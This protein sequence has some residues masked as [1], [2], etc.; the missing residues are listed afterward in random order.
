MN[1]NLEFDSMILIIDL[2]TFLVTNLVVVN[3][4]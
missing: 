3:Q 1:T 2:K 4:S